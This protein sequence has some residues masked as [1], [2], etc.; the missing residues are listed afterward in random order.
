MDIIWRPGTLMEGQLAKQ[1]LLAA[2][3]PCHLAGEHLSG[4]LGELPAFGLYRLMVERGRAG[5]AL[6]LLR[7]HGLV[8]GEGDDA[9][10]TGSIEA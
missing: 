4:G 8:D 5:E 9:G 2:G 10:S 6:S 1:L 3:I 7:E